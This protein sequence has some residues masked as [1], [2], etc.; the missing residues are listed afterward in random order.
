M[1]AKEERYFKFLPNDYFFIKKV[2]DLGI[3]PRYLGF[4]YIIEILD[5]LINEEKYVKSFSKEIYP[6]VAKKYNKN[7]SSIER[8]IRSVINKYWNNSLK[9]NLS[10]FWHGRNNP[11]CCDFIFI[12]KNYILSE[13]A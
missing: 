13:I 6:M 7:V 1:F 2:K 10:E 5:I 11:T 3:E 8:N 12:L 9:E 4:Y